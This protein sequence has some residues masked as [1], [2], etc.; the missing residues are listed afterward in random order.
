MTQLITD[1]EKI[2]R[3]YQ[4]SKPDKTEAQLEFR[5]DGSICKNNRHTPLIPRMRNTP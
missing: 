5:V 1:D 2:K 4:L 3:L